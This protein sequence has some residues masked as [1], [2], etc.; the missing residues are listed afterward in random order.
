MS[1]TQSF[2]VIFVLIDNFAQTDSTLSEIMNTV[3]LLRYMSEIPKA[4]IQGRGKLGVNVATAMV[5]D[6]ANSQL[7]RNFYR[8][9]RSDSHT[10]LLI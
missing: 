4:R 8:H 5:M 6:Q 7:G 1:R 3:N 9:P 2:F 10:Y